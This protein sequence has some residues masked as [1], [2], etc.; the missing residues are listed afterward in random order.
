MIGWQTSRLI[1][2]KLVQYVARELNNVFK[3]TEDYQRLR[4]GSLSDKSKSEDTSSLG[5]L[6][7]L[8]RAGGLTRDKTGQLKFADL[9]ADPDIIAAALKTAFRK[10]DDEITQAPIQELAKIKKQPGKPVSEQSLQKLLPALSGSCALLSYIDTARNKIHVAC[11]GDSRAVMGTWDEEAGKWKVDVL[12]EDQTGRNLKEVARM[13]AE[14]P[15]DENDRVIMRG[16]VLGGL[17]PTR[18]FG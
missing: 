9:D 5:F 10:L 1:S 14:H 18:A 7:R 4:L 3:S 13:Q 16:R 2:E 17:E 6:A 15:A 11:T 8:V 12:T